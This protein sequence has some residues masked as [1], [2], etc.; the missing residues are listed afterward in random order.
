MN[1]IIDRRSTDKH[2]YPPKFLH[3]GFA[4]KMPTPVVIGLEYS[5]HS[6]PEDTFI[7][8]KVQKFGRVLNVVDKFISLGIEPRS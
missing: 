8:I 4:A 6:N 5:C 1:V 3:C 7:R 2:L